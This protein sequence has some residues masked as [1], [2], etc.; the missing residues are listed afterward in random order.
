V[1]VGTFSIVG[2]A[3]G[4]E[5]QQGIH[6]E[7]WFPVRFGVPLWLRSGT[8]V[9]ADFDVDAKFGALS[10]TVTPPLVFRTSLQAATAYVAGHRQGS[11]VFVIQSPGWYS[12]M[13]DATPVGGPR[14]PRQRSMA[15]IIV[16]SSD[17]P[18]YDVSYRVVWRL[19]NASVATAG[20]P[21]LN[22]PR[23]NERLVTQYIGASAIP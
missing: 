23:P 12:L 14:C 17:C 21:R 20:L 11:V 6:G 13:H 9:R 18:T 22:V 3:S 1:F 7:R 8:V 15:E 5:R 2:Y 4:S 19:A 16:G 10:L